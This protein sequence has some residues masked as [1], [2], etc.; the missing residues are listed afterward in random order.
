ML[1]PQ[2]AK[3]KE[4]EKSWNEEE[5]DVIFLTDESFDQFIESHSSVL[6]KFYAPCN[7]KTNINI[8]S[9]NIN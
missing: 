9:N 8:C 3:E 4:P 7:N 1:N 5:H 2:P 6:V